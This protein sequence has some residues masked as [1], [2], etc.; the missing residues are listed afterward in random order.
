MKEICLKL[1]DYIQIDIN[2][3]KIIIAGRL[4]EKGLL[5][6]GQGADLAELSKRSFIE[7]LGRY[8][9]SLFNYLPEEL[10]EDLA[11]A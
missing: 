10:E 1:P 3:I 7:L 8:G 11:N 6:L 5:S 2:E 9:I 4:Y